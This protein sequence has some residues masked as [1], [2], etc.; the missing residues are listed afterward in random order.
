LSCCS[1][2]K[3]NL[4]NSQILAKEMFL[5]S[6]DVFPYVLCFSCRS[7]SIE[8]IPSDL[9]ELYAKYPGLQHPKRKESRIRDFLRRYMITHTNWFAKKIAD[10]LKTFDDLRLKALYNCHISANSSILDVGC[11]SGWFVYELYNLGYKNVMGID[12]ALSE[13]ITLKNGVK[14]YKK[15]LF[16]LDEKFDFISFHH[17]F[18]HLENPVEVL[19]KTASLLKEGGTCLIRVPNIESWSFRAFKEHWSGIHAPYH[20]FLPSQRGMEIF[21]EGSGFKIVDV[22]W[23]QLVESFLRSAC[24]TLDFASHDKFG[25]R[26]LL[27]GIPL[28]N[29]KIPLFTKKEIAFWKEK[30]KKVVEDHLTDYVDYYLKKSTYS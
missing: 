4:K 25:T 24:Y 8:S 22:R 30:T 7:L 23:E 12:P 11:G 13:D 17:S 21:C 18:E 19:K 28:G 26:T 16:D 5:G 3:N 14:L 1:I 20:L 10:S 9:E 29:R 2:C 15:N 6:R 27:K